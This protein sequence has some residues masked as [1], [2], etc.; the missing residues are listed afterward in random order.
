MLQVEEVLDGKTERPHTHTAQ[1][2]SLW[3]SCH[4]TGVRHG[5]EAKAKKGKSGGGGNSVCAISHMSC[6]GVGCVS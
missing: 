3:A 5:S 6:G 4:S 2:H 1:A